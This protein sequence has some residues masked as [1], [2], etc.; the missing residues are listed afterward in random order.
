MA[1]NQIKRCEDQQD[2]KQNRLMIF[3]KLLYKSAYSSCNFNIIPPIIGC[4]VADQ[5][6]NT[7]LV[8]E[9]STNNKHNYDSIKSYLSEDE[10]SFL[11][12][13][14]ISMYF[15]S[16][17]SFAGQTNIQ[18]L[19]NLEIH[20]SNIKIKI[21]YLFDKFMIILFLNANTEL[22]LKDK[23]TIVK[24]FEDIIRKNEFEFKHF[25]ASNSRK[26]L[27]MLET[28]GNAWLKN[29]NKI[30]LKHFQGTYLKRHKIIDELKSEIAPIIEKVLHEYLEHIQDDLVNNISKEIQNQI[31]DT[32]FKFNTS[33]N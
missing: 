17:K 24:Y 27:S 10:K 20:G 29:L 4:L 14:L 18:N 1:S 28:K 22:S 6:G 16:F 9:Y 21:F 32:L 2:K 31:Q 7:L 12:I 13:D 23:A 25:N 3:E 26:I 30:Y 19:S 5:Y 15:S 11:E 33:P 8:F